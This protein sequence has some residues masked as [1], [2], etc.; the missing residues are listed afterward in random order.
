M[1]D[2]STLLLNHSVSKTSIRAPQKTPLQSFV[3]FSQV[4]G[5]LGRSISSYFQQA[6]EV[7]API[8][9]LDLTDPITADANFVGGLV[10]SSSDVSA[11]QTPTIGNKVEAS[12]ISST[13]N[14]SLNGM[15]AGALSSGALDPILAPLGALIGGLVGGFSTPQKTVGTDTGSLPASSPD[16]IY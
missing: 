1:N 10:T 9:S 12:N 4:T 8:K 15:L 14:N 13:T 11:F 6:Q 2:I 16:L 7:K 5:S 3:P